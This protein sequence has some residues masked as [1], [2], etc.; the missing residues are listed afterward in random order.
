MFCDKEFPLFSISN[1]KRHI[2][3]KFVHQN[4]RSLVWSEGM[5]FHQE[6]PIFQMESKHASIRGCRTWRQS[7]PAEALLANCARL[8]RCRWMCLMHAKRKIN[9]GASHFLRAW[10]VMVKMQLAARSLDLWESCPEVEAPSCVAL[11][12]SK[13]H[14]CD[15]LMSRKGQSCAEQASLTAQPHVRA[16]MQPLAAAFQFH[17]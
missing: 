5:I 10:L 1:R 7:R 6:I 16:S 15:V 2:R 9:C 13:S 8:G 14:G 3:C 4:I 17:H 11:W 12:R